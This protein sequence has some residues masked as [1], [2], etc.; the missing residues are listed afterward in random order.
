MNGEIILYE[1]QDETLWN[2]DVIRQGKYF[3]DKAF[4]DSRLT[5]Y[6]LEA[7]IACCHTQKE[8]TPEKWEHILQLYNHLLTIEYSPVAALNRTYALA[9]ARSKE[10]AIQEA[11]KLQLLNNHFYHALLAE[12]YSELDDAV[13][14]AHFDKA[15]ELA[16]STRDKALLLKRKTHRL[17]SKVV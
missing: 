6:H 2:Q 17:E 1:D 3:L 9:K 11:E 8:D 13:S 10:E 16:I 7:G 14:V 5:K 12:L 15:I 4:I